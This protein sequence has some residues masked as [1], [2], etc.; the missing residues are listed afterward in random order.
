[1]M[2]SVHDVRFR[3]LC[4]VVELADCRP[5][6]EIEVKMRFILKCVKS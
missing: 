3:G 4:Q 2:S 1:L 5:V 6:V